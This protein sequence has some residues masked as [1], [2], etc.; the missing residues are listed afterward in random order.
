MSSSVRK[1]QKRLHRV[2]V[3]VAVACM[4]TAIFVFS[5]VMVAAFSGRSDISYYVLMGIAV[6]AL[7]F[8]GGMALGPVIQERKRRELAKKKG[9]G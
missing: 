1:K 5:Q 7:T 4:A 3:V 2:L 8:L 6:M 9:S